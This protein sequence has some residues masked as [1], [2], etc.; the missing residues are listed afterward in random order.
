MTCDDD[1]S[2]FHFG[3]FAERA[4]DGTRSHVQGPNIHNWVTHI[5]MVG[6]KLG[7]RPRASEQIER[8]DWSRET[9]RNI[10]QLRR[11]KGQNGARLLLAGKIE[12]GSETQKEHISVNVKSSEI[13]GFVGIPIQRFSLQFLQSL[14]NLRSLFL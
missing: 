13:V 3:D 7:Q 11:E 14:T 12:N 5:Q 10:D 4:A 2:V 8:F 6:C 9:H 1:G